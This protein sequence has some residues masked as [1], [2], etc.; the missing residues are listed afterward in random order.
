MQETER[1]IWNG[2]L[3]VTSLV[4]A[5][6]LVSSEPQTLGLIPPKQGDL[7]TRDVTPHPD[8]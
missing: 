1:T 7:A 3:H 4:V 2:I 8:P 6:V 5:V